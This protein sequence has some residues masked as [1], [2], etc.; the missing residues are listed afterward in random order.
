LVLRAEEVPI[1]LKVARPHNARSS[2]CRSV[3]LTDTVGGVLRISSCYW[4]VIR[5][6]NHLPIA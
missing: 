2:V 5:I 4:Q 1:I 3:R 6:A